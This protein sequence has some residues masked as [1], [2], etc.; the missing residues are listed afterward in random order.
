MLEGR[1]NGVL[2]SFT[3]RREDVHTSLLAQQLEISFDLAICDQRTL[4]LRLLHPAGLSLSGTG[5]FRATSAVGDVWPR[6]LGPHQPCPESGELPLP[7]LPSRP[8]LAHPQG[9]GKS[10]AQ[11]MHLLWNCFPTGLEALGQMANT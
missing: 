2:S 11:S 7:S 1:E 8:L 5:I 6:R 10:W 4:V 9:V 3:Y